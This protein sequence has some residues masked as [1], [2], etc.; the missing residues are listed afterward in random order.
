MIQELTE[1]SHTLDL[2]NFYEEAAARTG[3]AA[4]LQAK[5][6]TTASS[7]GSWLSRSVYRAISSRKP[8]REG[9]PSAFS[10]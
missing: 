7:S 4:M 2:E 9:S 5:R 1:L 3:Y 10:T 8:A 6:D